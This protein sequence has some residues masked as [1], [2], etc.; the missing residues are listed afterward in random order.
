MVVGVSLDDRVVGDFRK[1]ARNQTAEGVVVGVEV[2]AEKFSDEVWFLM[3]GGAEGFGGTVRGVD[4]RNAVTFLVAQCGSPVF[5]R[6][7]VFFFDFERLRQELEKR[8]QS[9]VEGH[10]E[11]NGENKEDD[12][13]NDRARCSFDAKKADQADDG[14]VTTGGRLLQ[15]ARVDEAFSV[16]VGMHDEKKV[17][18]VGKV[19][20]VQ[21]NACESHNEGCNDRIRDSC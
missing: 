3:R 16:D 10:V 21:P 19:D 5:R 15:G 4:A 1:A 9:S 18:S 8:V 17:V 6:E 13:E 12:H 20:E 14:E 11:E 7:K 2:R